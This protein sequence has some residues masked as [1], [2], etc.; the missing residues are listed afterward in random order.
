[1]TEGELKVVLHMKG[2]RTLV[3]V[4]GQGT[5]PLLET[6]E[7]STL[8]EALAAVPGVVAR[9]REGWAA[10]ARRPAYVGPPTEPKPAPVARAAAGAGRPQQQGPGEGQMRPLM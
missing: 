1:M 7:A 9:A 10:S 6:V 3:G 8:E 2:N 4:Q 5:D